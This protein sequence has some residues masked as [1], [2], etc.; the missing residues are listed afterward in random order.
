[1]KIIT[2]ETLKTFLDELNKKYGTEFY[3]KVEADNKYQS[4]GD[5]Y[6]KEE[7]DAKYQLKG[8]GSGDIEAFYQ[9]LKE[10]NYDLTNF[11][12]LEGVFPVQTL[13]SFKVN[14]ASVKDTQLSGTSAPHITVA[15]GGQQAKADGAGE[16]K[17]SGLSP[18]PSG[19]ITIEWLDY[20]GRSN[21]V[22]VP[23]YCVPNGTESIT[24][25]IVSQYQLNSKSKLN[26]PTSVKTVENG[27]FDSCDSL[28]SISLPACTTVA[29]AAFYNC[30]NLT[31]VSLPVCTSIGNSTFNNCSN[32]TSLSLPACTT[33]GRLAFSDCSNLTSLSLP[34]CTSISSR[35]GDTFKNCTKLQ[36][37]ILSDGWT[38][39]KGPGIPT[40]ATVYNQD[41]TK[42]VD[43][44]TLSWVNV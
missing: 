39:S 14:E 19:E 23:V 35:R 4:K 21:T 6:T 16:W 27:A 22:N 10:R 32:L 13:T 26:F 37:V 8:G 24:S 12:G 18:L 5:A 29:G 41:K 7:S 34:A 9:W 40:T 2:V 3:S 20:A 42:K 25:E 38:P 1:M 31:S 28:T 36:T 30:S 17:L 43:W 11:Q 33:V 15:Y 44:N